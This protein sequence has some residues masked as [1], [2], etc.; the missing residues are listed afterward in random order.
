MLKSSFFISFVSLLLFLITPATAAMEGAK[1]NKQDKS[2]SLA[3]EYFQRGIILFDGG[4]YKGAL[5]NFEKSYELRQYDIIIYNIGVCHYFL[6][7]YASALNELAGFLLKE[8]A[9]A[10]S[11]AANR[12][13]KIV[14]KIEGKA[15]IINVEV[16]KA[17]V[18]IRVDGVVFG[19]S[20]LPKGIYVESGTHEIQASAGEGQDWKGIFTIEAGESKVIQI[21]LAEK[22]AV[23]AR[24]EEKQDGE[25][26][27]KSYRELFYTFMALTIAAL[28]GGTVSGA[29]SMSKAGELHDLDRKCEAI[30]C[31]S[32]DRQPYD[33]YLAK[34]NN[35]YH[36]AELSGHISTGFFIASGVTAASSLL[37]FFLWR[38]YRKSG[39]KNAGA[40][41]LGPM[42]VGGNDAWNLTIRF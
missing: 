16:E 34:R 17:G 9:D 15:G 14:E 26:R 11:P 2:D 1:K 31:N 13:Y 10:D 35:V 37:F 20:P 29:V 21:K 23:P 3:K 19:T 8:G 42:L 4:D 30:H 25:G 40:S 5:E 38:P 36:D 32:G 39:E 24:N 28:G 22:P 27:M 6:G 18:E 7:E 33:D 41:S 12:A